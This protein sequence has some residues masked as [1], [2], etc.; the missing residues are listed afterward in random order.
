MEA[1]ILTLCAITWDL[2]IL[3][4][5]RALKVTAELVLAAALV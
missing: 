4:A 1:V 3:L 2:E 5:E